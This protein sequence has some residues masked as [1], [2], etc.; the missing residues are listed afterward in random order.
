MADE[1]IRRC[2]AKKRQGEGICTQRAGKGTNHVGWGQCH[3]HG[4]S[5]RNN[6]KNAERAQAMDAAE[7]MVATYGLPRNV[8][9]VAAVLEEIARTAGHIDWLGSVI[10]DLEPDALAWGRTKVEDIR[11]SEV[12][13]V[14]TTHAAA[15]NV[16]LDLYHRERAH[17][18]KV[19]AAAM[20]HGIAER[21]VRLAEQQGS[22]LAD[23][24]RA[25][26][27]DPELGLTEA[28]RKQAP[29][30]IRRHLAMVRTA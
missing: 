21:Q 4:G 16:W 25:F 11:A 8:D 13:G 2:G 18:V 7:K 23:V 29:G 6:V 26:L 12:A 3:L 1:P 5:M 30:V 20:S 9:P 28:Q 14:N 10:R 27:G 17:L 22:L 24:L 15:V 19:C